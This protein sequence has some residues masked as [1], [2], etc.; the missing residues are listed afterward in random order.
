MRHESLAIPVRPGEDAL[1]ELDALLDELAQ[2]AESESSP[3]E[4]HAALVSRAVSGLAAV[5]GAL[6]LRAA[7]G[8]W[9]LDARVEP[10]HGFTF[11]GLAADPRHDELLCSVETLG[12]ARAVSSG[13]QSADKRLAANPTEFLLLLCPIGTDRPAHSSGLLEVAQRPGSSPAVEQGYLRYLQAL[14]EIAEDYYRNRR[15]RVLNDRA[16]RAAEFEEFSR[17]LHQSLDL[18][19][20]AATAANEARRLIG[21]D[22]VSVVAC[23][24]RK[25]RVLAVSGQDQLERRAQ[26]VTGLE[27]LA[28]A[29]LAAQIPVWYSGDFAGLPREIAVPL[30]AS[31]DHSHARSV[32]VL[33]LLRPR[34]GGHNGS[35]VVGAFV[36]ECFTAR[37]LDEG[38]RER[39][40]AVARQAETALAN[41]MEHQGLPLFRVARLLQRLTLVNALRRLPRLAA[42]VIFA[43]CVLAALIFVRVDFRVEARGTLQPEVRRDVFAPADGIVAKIRT[44]HGQ[45]CRRGDVLIVLTSPQLDFESTRL[46][47][48]LQTAERRLASVLASRLDAAPQTAAERERYNQLTSEEEEIRKLLD[49]L[50]SQQEILR[51]QSEELVVKSPID[52]QVVT[53]DVEQSLSARPVRRG[54]VLV[55]V[56]QLDGPWVLE[57]EVPDSR[58]GPILV[59][60]DRGAIGLPVTFLVASTP[61][62]TYQGAVSRIAL[63]A[64]ARPGEQASV[65]LTSQIAGDRIPHARPGAAALPKIHCGRRALWYVWFHG[66]LEAIQKHVFF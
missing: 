28:T 1:R 16:N 53:F 31:L 29:V 4:F 47:G 25:C 36:I 65:L 41:A 64:Q 3:H 52:G 40:T 35:Q 45:H 63:T 2:L 7:E 5:G 24:G 32:A 19:V 11:A 46:S 54:Q 60:G 6:W 8:S 15:A 27:T 23:H 26:V 58:V 59:A 30:E 12:E 33:P 57:M 43:A 50:K 22:R 66:L 13:F 55:T 18:L 49:G 48:E 34:A 61:G 9:S 20:T 21:A 14:T 38:F 51:K 37:A 42:I 39:A 10:A 17:Q 44:S 56:A 62:V